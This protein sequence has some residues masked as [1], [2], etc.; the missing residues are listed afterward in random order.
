MCLCD[1]DE[2]G[3]EGLTQFLL[4]EVRKL[5]EQLR[6]SRLCE[7]RFSQRCRVAEEERNR[8]ERKAK[9]LQQDRI[10]LER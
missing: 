2:E 3:P 8:S 4:V 1:V 7:R 9:E 10:Q 5:R 6:M